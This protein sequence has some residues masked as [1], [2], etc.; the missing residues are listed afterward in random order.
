MVVTLGDHTGGDVWVED[1]A[2]LGTHAARGAP[3]SLLCSDGAMRV[4]TPYSPYPY[5]AFDAC[6]YHG[7]MQWEGER[8]AILFYTAGIP[9]PALT[10]PLAAH[11]VRTKT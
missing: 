3:T 11:S 4:G 10:P 6:A 8:W 1:G 9:P 7:D 5:L 2:I